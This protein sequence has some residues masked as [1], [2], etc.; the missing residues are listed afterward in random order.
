MPHAN[1]QDDLNEAADEEMA[2]AADLTWREL[3]KVIP[4]GDTFEGITPA[5]R[6]VVFERN[7]LWAAEEAGDICVEVSVY[8]VHAFEQGVKRTRLIPQ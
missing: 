2:K 6:E 7:Y 4:W 1:L 5:G 8:Q 3:A